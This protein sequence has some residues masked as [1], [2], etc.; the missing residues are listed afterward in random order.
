MPVLRETQQ[1]SSR[2]QRVAMGTQSDTAAA[3]SA[4]LQRAA[5]N[6]DC[7]ICCEPLSQGYV[8]RLPN[9]GHKLHYYC[10]NAFTGFDSGRGAVSRC[11]LC[12]ASL[13]VE[14]QVEGTGVFAV[15]P[16][17]A[18]AERPQGG[19]SARP[20]LMAECLLRWARERRDTGGLAETVPATQRGREERVRALESACGLTS[21]TSDGMRT[22]RHAASHASLLA[23]PGADPNAALQQTATELQRQR[24][25]GRCASRDG[26][27][28]DRARQTSERELDRK[29]LQSHEARQRA[30]RQ[31]EAQDAQE[32]KK[33]VRAQIAADR[34]ERAAAL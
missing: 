31:R 8:L 17:Q 34:A 14:Q 3:H 16:T 32:H 28:R 21:A 9:C 12:R 19:S 25:A 22:C 6:E 33:R 11:P 24:E 5:G 10:Y 2:T 29:A 27:G 7:A 23:G 26:M 4:R 18:R 30:R 13:I 1:H 15:P 20:D